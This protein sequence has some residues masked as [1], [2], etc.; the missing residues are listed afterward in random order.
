MNATVAAVD[1]AE[2]PASAPQPLVG[3]YRNYAMGLLLAISIINYLDRQVVHILAEPIKNDLHLADWQLGMLTGLAFGVLYTLLGLPIARLAERGNRPLIIA[4]ATA[5]WSVFTVLCGTVHNFTQLALAR[6]GVGIGEAGCTPPAHSLIMD[7]NPPAKRGS[8]L[9]FYGMG[10]PL[11]GLLGM[12]FGG[13]VAD[14]FGWRAA[15]LLAGIPGLLFATLTFLTLKEPRRN[16]LGIV[17][18]PEAH[19]TLGA[20]LRLVSAKRS[21]WLLGAAI[22]LNV[23]IAYGQG[24]FV[25]S[26]YLRNHAAELAEAARTVGTLLGFKMG[27]VGFLGLALG[28]LGGIGGA[29]GIFIGGR[30]SD[31][32]GPADPRRYIYLPALAALT[33]VPIFIGAMT[34]PTIWLSLILFGFNALFGNAWYGPTYTAWFSLVPAHMRATNSA[35]SLFVA[36]L[37]GLGL[38]PLGVGIL[39]DMFGATMG[40]GEGIRWALISLTGVGVVTGLLFWMTAKTFRAEMEA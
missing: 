40:S 5:A 32:L 14:A 35:V 33:C 1:P 8:A 25:A 39:S 34:T 18:K 6:V 28:L 13:L 16:R 36:N 2:V 4:S 17:R 3:A 31:G 20:M 37:I 26:F 11:G 22:T 12:A 21:Y 30:L 24:P 15:F 7:Y 38:A 23:F 10:A 9:A 29:T 27:S 19:E